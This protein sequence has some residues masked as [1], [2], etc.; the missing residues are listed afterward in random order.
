MG[1]TASQW[2]QGTFSAAAATRLV[3]SRP[4]EPQRR[5]EAVVGEGVGLAAVVVEGDPG[6]RAWCRGG[7]ECRGRGAVLLVE[8][9][10]VEVAENARVREL[11]EGFL[12]TALLPVRRRR[13]HFGGLA[14][15]QLERAPEIVAELGG[16]L[17]HEVR[18][19]ALARAPGGRGVGHLA[20]ASGLSESRLGHAKVALEVD[21]RGVPGRLPRAP[22]RAIVR[23]GVA[24]R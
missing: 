24:A 5:A 3:W 19:A 21:P 20:V 6:H 1:K 10:L 8:V 2:P 16:A 18:G 17:E 13:G 23:W 15:E 12:C 11:G 22:A 14:R 4:R 9:L 7:E